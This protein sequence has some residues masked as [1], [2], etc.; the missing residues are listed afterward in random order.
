MSIYIWLPSIRLHSISLYLSSSSDTYTMNQH[1][2]MTN[3][4]LALPKILENILSFIDKDTTSTWKDINNYEYSRAGILLW[5]SLVNKFWNHEAMRI[6]WS[7][8]LTNEM[9]LDEII[10][11][12][13][14]DRR[15][16]Y[17]N[18]IKTACIH[19]HVWVSE[20]MVQRALDTV[21]FPGIRNLCIYSI[22]FIRL[23]KRRR[24]VWLIYPRKI[25][26]IKL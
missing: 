2:T 6:L 18:Y 8:M 13:S 4:A 12:I 15:Q 26:R 21:S 20:W 10:D 16:I 11:R 23:R 7:N 14:P 24:L 19:T 1:L 22:F 5:C 25:D 9:R 3:R 17:A